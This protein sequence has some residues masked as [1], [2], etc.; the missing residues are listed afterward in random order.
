MHPERSELAVPASNPR[1]I[2][3]ALASEAD[4][5]FLD[6]EDAVAASEKAQ[7]RAHVIAA[8]REK[9]WRGKPPAYRINALDTSFCYRDLIEVV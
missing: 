6:L 3:K 9:N 1:M 7:A 2:D 8:L 5:A 4:V